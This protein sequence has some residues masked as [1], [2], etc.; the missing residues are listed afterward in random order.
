MN[1]TRIAMLLGGTALFTLSQLLTGPAWA[2]D[3]EITDGSETIVLDTIYVSG[4]NLARR[5][6]DTAS[7]VA[8]ITSEDLEARPEAYDVQRAVQDVPN[9]YYPGTVGT[10]PIIRGQDTQGPATGG[11]AFYSGTVPRATIN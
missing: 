4:E 8:V 3:A 11:S 1:S 2:Q 5:L 7:S 9:V 6:Q 10:A